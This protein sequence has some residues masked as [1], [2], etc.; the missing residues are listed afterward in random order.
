[1]ATYNVDGAQ[2]RMSELVERSLSGEKIT[3]SS[4]TG[5]VVMVS[6]ED[7]DSLVDALSVMMLPEVVERVKMRYAG[8]TGEV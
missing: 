2:G 4:K 1:M 3:I 7:W 6:E 5:N 8:M